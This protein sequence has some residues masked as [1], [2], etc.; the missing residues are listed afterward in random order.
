MERVC[1]LSSRNSKI[2]AGGTAICTKGKPS[3]ARGLI[4]GC[5]SRTLGIDTVFAENVAYTE[6]WGPKYESRAAVKHWFREW[7]T[8]GNVAA[9]DIKQFFHKGDQTVV[10]WYFK[11][12]MADSSTDEFDGVPLIVWTPGGKIKSLQEFG[13]NTDRYD[14]YQEGNTPQFREETPRWF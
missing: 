10:E 1:R 13:C 8:R 9:W 2:C 3:S 4:C 11:A 6:S 5:A 14:P 7:N 12:R